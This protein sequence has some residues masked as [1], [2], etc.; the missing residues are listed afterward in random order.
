M[1]RIKYFMILV[2]AQFTICR[3]IAQDDLLLDKDFPDP[4]VI[5]GEDGKYYA[6]ATQGSFQ[7]KT[8]HIQ[9]AVSGDLKNWELAGDALPSKPSWASH[10]F[11]APHVLYDKTLK[12]YVMFYSGES[13]DTAI[14]KCI[15][16]AFSDSPLGPFTDKGTPLV[17]GEGFVNIDPMAFIDPATGKRLLYWG[18]GFQPIKVQEMSSDWTT[19]KMGTSPKDLVFPKKEKEYTRLLEGAWVNFH[20]GYY[21]LYYSGDNCCGEH[22][23]YAVMV[24]RSKHAMGPFTR[25]AEE[26][27]TG[28]SAVLEKDGLWNA[29]GHNSVIKDKKGQEWIFYH[30]IKRSNPAEGRVMCRRP[31]TYKDGWPVIG[32]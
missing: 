3:C 27:G 17:C 6:Y 14:G 16:V 8:L 32:K 13:V 10:D 26:R 24:A 2:V 21:Y 20:K 18:S 25:L 28:S 12:K 1:K 30:A 9:V 22:A 29:P 31:I 4:T 23:S 5:L 7:G 11:W 19:F 15:G